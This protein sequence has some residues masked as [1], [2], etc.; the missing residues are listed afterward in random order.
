MA[1]LRYALPIGILLLAGCQTTGGSFCDIARP[2]RLTPEQV[3]QL[4]DEQVRQFLAHNEKGRRLC[5]WK[6]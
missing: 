1:S 6:S 5:R 4:T 3:D 2:I